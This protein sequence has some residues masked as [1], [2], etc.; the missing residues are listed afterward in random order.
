MKRFVLI[1]ALGASISAL[2]CEEEAEIPTSSFGS[3]VDFS[4]A[5][6]GPTET[7][8]P[9][10]FDD[11]DSASLC[12]PE[13]AT[14]ANLFG[15]VLNRNPARL[16]VVQMNGAS[17]DPRGVVDADPFVPGFSGIVLEDAP[18]RVLRSEDW[19][20]FYVLS[21][22]G[23]SL[24]RI[25]L[26][27]L[28]E[29]GDLDY[30]QDAPLGLPDAPSDG[31]ILGQRLWVSSA[32]SGEI[33]S[34]TIESD[35]SLTQGSTIT[36]DAVV[37]TMSEAQDKIL[38]TWVAKPTVS[39][40][41]Q[42]FSLLGEGHL[43]PACAD[44]VDN[45]ADGVT[46][47]ADPDCL[48]SQDAQE[49]GSEGP[50]PTLVDPLETLSTY[51]PPALAPCEDGVDN[52]GDGLTDAH[53]SA[54]ADSIFGEWLPNCADGLDN[55]GDGLS[56]SDDPSCHGPHDTSES[57]TS[58]HG[59]YHATYVDGRHAS[60]QDFGQF[61]YVLDPHH[62]RILVFEVSPEGALTPVHVP[63]LAAE[64]PSLEYEAYPG[65]SAGSLSALSKS[66]LTGPSHA[67][68]IGLP[69]GSLGG[70]GLSSG[71]VRGEL[72]SRIIPDRSVVPGTIDWTPRGCAV[73]SSTELCTQP[74]LD[75]ATWYVFM[76]TLSGDVLLIE[77]IRR[78]VPLHRFAQVTVLPENRGTRISAPV[79]VHR[80]ASKT[81]NTARA[82]GVPS[83]GP[84]VEEELVS[85]LDGTSAE[86]VRHYGIWP[87][88]YPDAVDHEAVANES[89]TLTYEGTIP[90][91]RGTLG[92]FIDAFTFEDPRADFCAA[93]VEVGDWLTLEVPPSSVPEPLQRVAEV[94]TEGGQSCPLLPT[95]QVFIDVPVSE[96]G[97]RTLGVDLAAARS[98]PALPELDKALIEADPLLSLSECQGAREELDLYAQSAPLETLLP[99]TPPGTELLPRFSSYRV[100]VAG[101]WA[102]VGAR[103]GFLHKRAWQVDAESGVGQCA[104]SD[105][106]AEGLQARVIERSDA[107]TYASCPPSL[108]ELRHDAPTPLFTAA[109]AGRFTNVSFSLDVF[110]GCSLS[111]EG[112]NL[113]PISGTC[114]GA[115]RLRDPTAPRSPRLSVS[116]AL[117]ARSCTP[118]ASLS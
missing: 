19:S 86:L 53:D 64:V 116:T 37:H 81:L 72:W 66:P 49:S 82:D 117:S 96:V 4:Y 114:S 100:R 65:G 41:D 79:F 88:G 87:A 27:G 84:D 25:V 33:W 44:G 31:L 2:G 95:T 32:T 115:L 50:R 23:Q 43:V 107:D 69:I 113:G 103:S 13:G 21:A 109:D 92:R 24:Q 75:D 7:F 56:D 57:H 83:L 14:N 17:S 90:D 35:G 16:H 104:P 52:D 34:F 76:P 18:L 48:S 99:D 51:F 85:A 77:A 101:A 3:P 105:I 10:T 68:E 42:S 59:P 73:G 71:Q 63:G 36:T 110:E 89:W 28:D 46:D 62:E 78:G 30:T 47:A 8:R 74:E 94:R 1:C 11:A 45:D 102:V 26:H 91:T 15:V 60:G 38:V 22:G 9:T 106:D 29:R 39:L 5:C 67:G 97:T 55:D 40:Y 61:V 80:G 93:G 20:A 54:C 98:F 112:A 111:D 70:T 108:E 12:D 118:H 58:V 6:S